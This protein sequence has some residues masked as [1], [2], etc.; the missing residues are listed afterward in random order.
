M[1]N[2]VAVDAQACSENPAFSVVNAAVTI[3]HQIAARYPR[4][5]AAA[6]RSLSKSTRGRTDAAA[7]SSADECPGCRAPRFAAAVPLRGLL[8]GLDETDRC[9]EK[10]AVKPDPCITP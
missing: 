3:A 8:V 2:N 5:S 9:R 1:V 4:K 7:H 10:T 6:A